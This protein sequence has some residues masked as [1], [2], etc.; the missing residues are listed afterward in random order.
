MT[1][2]QL[3]IFLEVA[4][5]SHVTRAA[6]TLGLTQSAVSAAIAALE[7]RHAVALFHRV[8]RRIEI[9][10]AGLALVDHAR[11][12]L[13]QVAD[14]ET[15]LDD[16]TGR[17]A[18]P[19]RVQASQTV[20]SYFLP[21]ALVAFRA[22]HP[23]VDLRFS[24][25]NTASVARAVAAGEADLG[26]VEGLVHDSGLEIRALVQDRLKVVIGANHPWAKGRTL[27]AGDLLS[28]AWVLRETG[29][30]T[31]AA[32][33]A[34][35]AAGGVDGGALNVLLELP[36]NEACLAAVQSGKAATIV[37]GRA[38]APHIAQGIVAVASY[39]FEPRWF[40]LLRHK[41]RAPGPA[42]RAFIAAVQAQAA[43][44]PE[45]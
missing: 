40:T 10:P 38:A 3:R 36:S 18:G 24:D 44:P 21:P 14:A 12:I 16:S 43:A 7:S 28:G 5:I 1:L 33:D 9:T 25:G 19:L 23:Q 34:A 11:A 22:Q 4:R 37:S 17:I 15:A 32:F 39:R 35:L 13:R 41:D 20:A 8:G 27:S 30:G 2:E 31:R 6:E 42:A 26:V 29:S 45:D